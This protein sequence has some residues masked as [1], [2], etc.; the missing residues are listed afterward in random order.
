MPFGIM[1]RIMTIKEQ[2]TTLMATR[3]GKNWSEEAMVYD[4]MGDSSRD[5]YRAL[6][7]ALWDLRREGVV[8]F[9]R[10]NNQ[11]LWVI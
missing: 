3:K 10:F 6:R 4:I 5:S 11:S 1:M 8:K 9:R 2:I 7:A